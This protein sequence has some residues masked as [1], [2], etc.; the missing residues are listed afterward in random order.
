MNKIEKNVVDSI[1]YINLGVLVVFAGL[2]LIF[3]MTDDQLLSSLPIVLIVTTAISIS[4]IVF[5]VKRLT[6]YK[7]NIKVDQ[8]NKPV[9]Y[10]QVGF[11]VLGYG[12]I[13]G[14]ISILLISKVS[15]LSNGYFPAYM[16]SQ[17]TCAIE[18]LLIGCA[19][20]VLALILYRVYI[21]RLIITPQSTVQET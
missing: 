2:F 14:G 10:A 19:F 17:V 5:G 18:L 11:N 4:L 13:G 9:V 16:G 8:K 20:G 1:S 12:L 21:H 3:L 6:Q 7:A 15:G